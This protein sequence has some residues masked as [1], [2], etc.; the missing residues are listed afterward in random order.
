[1]VKTGR[2][3]VKI[4]SEQGGKVLTTDAPAGDGS[5]VWLETDRGRDNQQ[6]RLTPTDDRLA[7]LIESKPSTHA[8][9]ATTAANLP[10][11]AEGGDISDPT[12]PILWR[13][14][15]L[16]WQQWMILRL[17]FV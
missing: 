15:W 11:A 4:A 12:S 1:L 14:H 2:D 10:A 16:G 6:W 17:P 8:L 9:D 7:F 5:W 3:T 13:S